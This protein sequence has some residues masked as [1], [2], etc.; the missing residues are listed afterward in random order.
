[1]EPTN[2]STWR[3]PDNVDLERLYREALLGIEGLLATKY[4]LTDDEAMQVDDMVVQ[5]RIWG[6]E[7]DT[8]SGTLQWL[9]KDYLNE[10]AAVRVNL[11]AVQSSLTK[12]TA[13]MLRGQEGKG[14]AMTDNAETADLEDARV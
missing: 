5:L 9:T 13:Q 14:E 3:E 10:A 8:T 12:I 11:Q 4:G 2:K 1:M 6:I 7:L